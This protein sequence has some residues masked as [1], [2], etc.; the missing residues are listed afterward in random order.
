MRLLVTRE[1]YYQAGIE[2]LGTQGAGGLKVTSLCK[3]LGVTT[4]SFYGYFGSLDGFIDEF[5]AFWEDTFTERILVL[6]HIPDEPSAQ[7]HLL[8]ELVRKLPHA[9]EAAFRT[10]SQTNPAVGTTQR[11]VDERRVRELATFLRPVA[12]SDE[13]ALALS[14]LAITLLVGLQQWRQPVTDERYNLVF[15]EFERIVMDRLA[16]SAER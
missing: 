14:T 5:L 12:G 13:S 10:W 1:D 16:E 6:A 15:D 4:G 11:A 3:T 8:K 7:I 2:I 9:A